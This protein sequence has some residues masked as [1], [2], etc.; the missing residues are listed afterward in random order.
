MID[1]KTTER[2]E[3]LASETESVKM[4]KYF[5]KVYEAF[6]SSAHKTD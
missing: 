3:R 2:I 1:E 6:H 5:L 4:T